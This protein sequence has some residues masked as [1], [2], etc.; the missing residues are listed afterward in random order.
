MDLPSAAALERIKRWVKT[1]PDAE[2]LWA[3]LEET[4]V[5]LFISDRQGIRTP[6]YA[7]CYEGETPSETRPLMGEPALAM[8]LRYLSK[9]LSLAED[10]GEPPDH[11]SIE[12]EYLYFL[13]EKGWAEKD[14]LLLEEAFSFSSGIMLP[15]VMNLK[16]RLAS[17]ENENP[18]YPLIAILL[19][20]ILRVI[21]ELPISS[22]Q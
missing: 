11:L 8:Q 20:G 7:S 10:I 4:H 2:A 21:A 3:D 19:C 12:L 9:G 15:W 18:F 17:F 13:L 6:L 22:K 14:D 16:H 5:R 1:F